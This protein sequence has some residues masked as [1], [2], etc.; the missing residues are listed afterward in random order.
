LTDFIEE[1]H[2]ARHLRRMRP[3]YL[4]RRNA[5]VKNI[6]GFLQPHNIDAGIHFTA[7]LPQQIDDCA[8]VQ[9]AV[10]NGISLTA[11]STCYAG[12]SPRKGLILGFG[13]CNERQIKSAAKKL[14]S[15]LAEFF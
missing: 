11:L 3:I 2:F 9:K 13:G 12:T 8:V 7:F 4:S 14:Q 5:L 6:E 10:E 15:I 1:G